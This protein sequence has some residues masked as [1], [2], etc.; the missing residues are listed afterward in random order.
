MSPYKE[1]SAGGVSPL[2]PMRGRA[3]QVFTSLCQRRTRLAEY[4]EV[5]AMAV[6][7]MMLATIADGFKATDI[8]ASRAPRDERRRNAGER[9]KPL[10][11]FVEQCLRHTEGMYQPVAILL[12]A[13]GFAPPEVLVLP[14]VTDLPHEM[15]DVVRS[16]SEVAEQYVSDIADGRVDD[17]D[18]LL[19]LLAVLE[20]QVTE[21]KVATRDALAQREDER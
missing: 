9:A 14:R 5:G 20:R 18:E 12:E 19:S 3:V 1:G 7:A 15:V 8:C 16:F 17:L 4:D 6:T 21:A 11:D 10:E 2:G 13:M